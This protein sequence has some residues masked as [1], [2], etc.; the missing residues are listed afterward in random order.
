VL[1]VL[2]DGGFGRVYLSYDDDLGR[3]VAIKVPHRYR[4]SAPGD[5]EAYLSE[6]RILAHLEHDAIVPVYD[7]GRTDDGLC[8]VVSKYIEGG[9]LA[10][11]IKQSPLTFAAAA[12]V[13]AVIAD[14]L[15]CAHM[16]GIVHRDIKPANIL[17]DVRDR[18]YLADFG[19]ALKE[20]DFGKEKAT[21]GTLRY[22]SPEQVRGEGH[23]VDGRSDIFSLG[24][25]FYELLTGRRLFPTDRLSQPH[26]VDPRPPRQIDDSI[27]K[28][29][30]RICL[31]ALSHRVADRYSTAID[32]SS[33][34]RD[35]LG[36]S[37]AR[38]EAP[39]RLPASSDR[40]PEGT[41]GQ[42]SATTPLAIVPKG[43]RSFDGGDADFFL[44]L[45]PGP[46]D[47]SGLP[48]S[49]QFWKTR[50]EQTEP[51]K[52]FR[53]GLIYG[54]SGCGK[55]SFLK[56]GVIPRVG[57]QVV[58]LYIES[59]PDESETRLSD[60]THERLDA[61]CSKRSQATDFSCFRSVVPRRLLGRSL[62]ILTGRNGYVSD[63]STWRRFRVV[64]PVPSIRKKLPS[65]HLTPP[66]CEIRDCGVICCECRETSTARTQYHVPP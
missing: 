52:T 34:L 45:L 26:F 44:E 19:I 2:G 31:K 21:V 61:V 29:L 33:D 46:S 5:I 17:L 64:S 63:C 39:A 60:M 30:E 9:D 66:R 57:S 32:L 6:A 1:R 16:N 24:I 28:E 48:E 51:D 12:E 59:T 15:H 8:F 62:D 20:E 35:F 23:L 43:L 47:R 55:S 11:K 13:V 22:M 42:P 14:A 40:V 36:V 10:T 58:C 50:I 56:A 65:L 7:C 53:V 38:P 27:P 25:V 4:V 41:S 3:H 49:V 54:P 18:P 37:T